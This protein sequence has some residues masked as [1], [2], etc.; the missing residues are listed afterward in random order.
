MIIFAVAVG[1]TS[2]GVCI[3]NLKFIATSGDRIVSGIPEGEW[4]IVYSGI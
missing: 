3:A 1:A 2:P 4:P